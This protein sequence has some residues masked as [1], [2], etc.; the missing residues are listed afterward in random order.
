MPN[1]TRL[2]DIARAIKLE[3]QSGRSFHV[4][5]ALRHRKIVE[6]GVNNLKKCSP[7][8]LKYK[9][10]N[11]WHRPDYKARIHA[12]MDCIGRLNRLD[13]D[14]KKIII[15]SI[16]IDNNGRV[17]CGKPCPNCSYQLGLAGY[18]KVFYS[19]SNGQFNKL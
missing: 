2:V 4:A 12:E 10:Y 5:F 1:F 8:S 11:D 3:K 18:T 16:R 9:P 13:I 7:A 19:D 17:S 15:V 14:H 6:I